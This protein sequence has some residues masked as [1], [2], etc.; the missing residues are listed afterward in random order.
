[1]GLRT[2][3]DISS[4]ITVGKD[5]SFSEGEAVIVYEDPEEDDL[6]MD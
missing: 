3:P 2:T 5:G 6:C 4:V 1:M